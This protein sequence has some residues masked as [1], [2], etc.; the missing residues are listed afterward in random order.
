MHLR[1]LLFNLYRYNFFCKFWIQFYCIYMVVFVFV[2]LSFAIY[3]LYYLVLI[4]TVFCYYRLLLGLPR[5]LLFKEICNVLKTFL[6]K[7][8]LHTYCIHLRL[9]WYFTSWKVV[10]AVWIYLWFLLEF[11]SV[12]SK[13]QPSKSLFVEAEKKENI[14][15]TLLLSFDPPFLTCTQC[16]LCV[17]PGNRHITLSPS[18]ETTGS[19]IWRL[20]LGGQVA[21]YLTVLPIE[22]HGKKKI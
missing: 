14:C 7:Q 1:P 4:S 13:F 6:I 21:S 18:F 2:F 8:R 16:S 15:F 12:N 20:L 19:T 9:F 5:S 22:R 17:S 11:S 3:I 10:G